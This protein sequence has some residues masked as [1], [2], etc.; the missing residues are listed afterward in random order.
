MEPR[1]SGVAGRRRHIC[2]EDAAQGVGRRLASMPSWQPTTRPVVHVDGLAATCPSWRAAPGAAG[3]VAPS[4][5]RLW[6]P[7]SSTAWPAGTERPPSKG[8][9]AA[10]AARCGVEGGTRPSCLRCGQPE[11][12]RHRP[13]RCAPRLSRG[14]WSP[15]HGQQRPQHRRCPGW[16]PLQTCL[17]VW[18]ASMP[19]S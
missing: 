2:P 16:P 19:N 17:V 8:G 11:C 13:P 1:S 14:C 12:T 4:N 15:S 6:R 9:R 3:A 7:S 10:P 18:S 5:G